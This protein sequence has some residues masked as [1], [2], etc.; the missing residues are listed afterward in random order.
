MSRSALGC[1]GTV[2][3]EEIQCDRVDYFLII[4]L[5]SKAS[6]HPPSYTIVIPYFHFL[7]I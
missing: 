6:K 1:R 3:T 2:I 4:S 7:E 5:F